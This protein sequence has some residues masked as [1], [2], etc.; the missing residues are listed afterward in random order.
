MATTIRLLWI[1]EL[2]DVECEKWL[3]VENYRAV[4]SSNQSID[5]SED[6]VHQRPILPLYLRSL[7]LDWE[8]VMCEYSLLELVFDQRVHIPSW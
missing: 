2:V 8:V 1:Q 7:A 4:D 6:F 3:E 5:Q